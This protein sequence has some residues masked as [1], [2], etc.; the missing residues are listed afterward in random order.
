M[1]ITMVKQAMLIFPDGSHLRVNNVEQILCLAIIPLHCIESPKIATN[2]ITRWLF[3][4]KHPFCVTNIAFYF[5]IQTF[6]KKPPCLSALDDLCRETLDWEATVQ[7]RTQLCTQLCNNEIWE[8]AD[9]WKL[10]RVV[11]GWTPITAPEWKWGP[12]KKWKT[13][14]ADEEGET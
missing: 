3:F 5:S 11:G 6:R 13:T 1:I 7:L 14:K 8:E 4:Y 9:D 12:T 10:T 2:C